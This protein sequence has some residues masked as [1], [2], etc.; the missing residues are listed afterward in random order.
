MILNEEEMM[1]IK[2]GALSFKIAGLLTGIATGISI[3]FIGIWDGFV[4]P[5]KCEL[6]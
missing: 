2:G 5:N 6:R 1:D 3:F 4:N